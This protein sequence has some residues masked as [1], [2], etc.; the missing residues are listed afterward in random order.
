MKKAVRLRSVIDATIVPVHSGK[1]RTKQAVNGIVDRV[2]LHDDG[3]LT[4][5]FKDKTS[6]HRVTFN[7][8]LNAWEY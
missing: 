4:G 6:V 5:S 7:P 1:H 2:Y 8:K 3:K